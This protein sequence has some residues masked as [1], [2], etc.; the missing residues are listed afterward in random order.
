MLTF[1]Q[2]V[3]ILMVDR[4]SSGGGIGI[5]RIREGR[6]RREGRIIKVGFRIE[7]NRRRGCESKEELFNGGSCHSS[8]SCYW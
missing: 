5:I 3:E 6:E 7:V 1:I 2:Q 4:E 8:A